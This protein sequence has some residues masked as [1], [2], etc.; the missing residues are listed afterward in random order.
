MALRTKL[1]PNAVLM[2]VKRELCSEVGRDQAS[3]KALSSCGLV[4]ALWRSQH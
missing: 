3:R 4:K 2:E 1:N